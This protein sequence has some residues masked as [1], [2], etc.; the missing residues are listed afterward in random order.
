MPIQSNRFHI[1]SPSSGIRVRVVFGVRPIG[2]VGHERKPTER[3]HHRTKRAQGAAGDQNPQPDVEHEEHGSAAD[4]SA[5]RLR[6]G[7]ATVKKIAP[8]TNRLGT[9]I[10]KSGMA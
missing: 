6:D 2:R 10:T 1:S 5:S 4:R 3:V 9:A 8:V 7:V